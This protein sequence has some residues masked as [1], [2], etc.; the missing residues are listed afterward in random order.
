[1]KQKKNYSEFGLPSFFLLISIW[2]LID[3]YKAE[4]S[5]ENL[6]LIVPAGVVVI[7]L[8]L[9][10]LASQLFLKEQT[11]EVSVEVEEK[12]DK[13]PKEEVSVLGAMIILGVYVLTMNWIGF[14]VAT[15][16]FIASL[17]FLQ[18]ERRITMLIGFSLVFSFLVSL[19]FEYM[20]PYPMPM[21]LGKEFFGGML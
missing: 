8:C 3:A 6:L 4:A 11:A 7:C 10:I 1:M 9:W 2:Y 13:E 17:M 12:K 18:G 5:V 19:F 21:L 14:D 15:F 16:G 20:I